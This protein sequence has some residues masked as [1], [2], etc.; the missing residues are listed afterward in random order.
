MG[1][2]IEKE[3]D[4]VKCSQRKIRQVKK[5]LITELNK[6]FGPVYYSTFITEW[7]DGTF[8]VELRHGSSLVAGTGLLSVWRWYDGKIVYT[9]SEIKSPV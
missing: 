8:M 5:L 2:F 3:V 7:N 4:I 6:K 1:I 9:E